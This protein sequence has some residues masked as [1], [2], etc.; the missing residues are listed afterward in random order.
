MCRRVGTSAHPTYPTANGDSAFRKAE[1]GRRAAARLRLARRKSC[2]LTVLPCPPSMIP[3]QPDVP[4]EYRS[5]SKCKDS[6]P[7]EFEIAFAY[8]PMVDIENRSIFAHEAL[9]RGP[10]GES[11]ATVLSRVTEANRYSSTRPAGSGAIR[12]L[13]SSGSGKPSRSTFCQM[14]SMCPPR[15]FWG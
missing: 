3:I 11:A 12:G 5:C 13:P 6:E 1:A 4:A 9:V 14:P 7:L 10:N 2:I 8:Q 15:A